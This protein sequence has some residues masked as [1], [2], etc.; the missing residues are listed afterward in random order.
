MASVFPGYSPQAYS[1]N[2]TCVHCEKGN[3][4]LWKYFVF[5][6][7]PLT[8]FYFIILFFKVNTTTSHLHGYVAFAQV[9]ALPQYARLFIII[10]NSKPN[11]NLP[12]KIIGT[13]YGFWNLDFFR[14]FTSGICL[15]LSPL[16]VVAL[17][18]IIAVYPFF[19]TV[20]SYVLIELHDRNFKIVVLVWKPFR[21]I[22]TLFRR[23]WDIR[24]SLIDAYVSFFQLSCFKILCTSFDLLIPT[25]VYKVEDPG[26]KHLVVYYDGTVDF[27]GAE[28]PSI[29]Y[30]CLA[31]YAVVCSHSYN[32]V[33]DIFLSLF[34]VL[35]ESV[36]M[37]L[38]RFEYICGFP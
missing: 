24:T 36:S 25:Y 1:Y 13:L 14:L 23:K 6:L 38:S 7:A 11:F 9:I 17:D 34:P 35:N 30:S 8:C 37:P 26:K 12:I 20:L 4:N 27:F 32:A 15:N 33:T 22:F 5:S 16:S 21:C 10:I 18:Y 19:L 2:L 28:Q 31:I 29:C 3:A